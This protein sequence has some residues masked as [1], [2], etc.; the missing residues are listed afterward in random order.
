[1]LLI[2]SVSNK[3]MSSKLIKHF[4]REHAQ[5]GTQEHQKKDR[6]TKPT[7][8]LALFIFFRLTTTILKRM[9]GRTNNR[10][11]MDVSTNE[12]GTHLVDLKPKT[13]L[14]FLAEKVLS[15]CGLRSKLPTKCF[16]AQDQPYLGALEMILDI[17]H[18]IRVKVISAA[19]TTNGSTASLMTCTNNVN[20]YYNGSNGFK[21]TT[22]ELPEFWSPPLST[23]ETR[24]C[25][26]ALPCL[27]DCAPF[28]DDFYRCVGQ[29]IVCSFSSAEEPYGAEQQKGNDYKDGQPKEIYSLYQCIDA[30]RITHILSTL[31]ELNVLGGE[32][33]SCIADETSDDLS[34]VSFLDLLLHYTE[35]STHIVLDSPN[36]GV[37]STQKS[38]ALMNS[39]FKHLGA[40]PQLENHVHIMTRLFRASA[41]AITHDD[42]SSSLK[43]AHMKKAEAYQERLEEELRCHIACLERITGMVYEKVDCTLRR[44]A[45][46]RMGGLLHTFTLTNGTSRG[47]RLGGI[48]LGLENTGAAFVDSILKLIL[49]ILR[50]VITTEDDGSGSVTL[51][52]SYKHLLRHVLLPL[53]KPS[54]MILWRDQQPLLSL[55]HKTLVQCI[56]AIATIDKDLIGEVI[57]Y[58]IH[59]DIWPLEGK[60]E[61]G[62][63]V[64]ANTPKLV[65][66]LH[67]IDTYIGLLEL[68]TTK[69]TIQHSNVIL[70]LVL[71]LC[72]CI[73]SDNSRSSERA[74]EF[75]KNCAFKVV[76]R[77]NL[78][79]LMQPL[80]RALC[81]VD[82]GMEI[83]W[84]PTVRKM[85]LLVLRDLK[86]FD[87]G[88]FEE[89]CRNLFSIETIPYIARQAKPNVDLHSPSNLIQTH[90]ESLSS[91]M[92]S[93]KKAMGSWRPPQ[94]SS[95]S[96]PEISKVESTDNS[97]MAMSP[98]MPRKL[99]HYRKGAQPPLAVTGVA[100]WA[101]QHNPLPRLKTMASHGKT[102]NLPPQGISL[103]GSGEGNKVRR[104]L[105]MMA[106]RRKGLAI[107]VNII[108]DSRNKAN[109][110]SDPEAGH[111]DGLSRVRNYMEKLR[112]P[113]SE[114]E[115]E[116]ED[117]ISSWA[118]AQACESPVLLA[119]LKFHDLVF[120]DVLGT[121]AFSTVKVSVKIL[122][123]NYH[124]KHVL[125]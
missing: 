65:L 96:M 58:I 36:D 52:D 107:P 22:H 105:G 112:I 124:S 98:P 60:R 12:S 97:L 10:N 108:A 100:P 120:G 73:S 106:L 28:T 18:S 48:H 64:Q 50:G 41:P 33:K 43:I 85:T 93:L 92:I 1:M 104:H 61:D 83:P 76:V 7:F 118:K 62:G 34:R 51:P 78:S 49:R 122:M 23:E 25:N 90:N 32:N 101:I 31:M 39:I 3:C 8:H 40:L 42:S 6:R 102:V 45:R 15:A 35:G 67:E 27:E 69:T 114:N 86:E 55:Y 16:Q 110:Q 119:D 14:D 59:P 79:K 81:R 89:S 4:E 38:I 91:D 77:N 125:C 87:K 37:R 17:E 75:F 21:E 82:A 47:N 95:I 115:G 46:L 44:K 24:K 113:R 103:N 121:G 68:E 70:P 71:R 11:G 66:L 63:T 29:M 74:L 56:G 99:Q 54:G 88:L 116:P 30:V 5:E 19:E 26:T 84:N 53:H 2:F 94:T 123:H 13:K 72:T 9:Q 57:Q 117:G 20:G 109:P 80:L 111:E